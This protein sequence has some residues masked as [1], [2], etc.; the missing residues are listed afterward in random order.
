M[1]GN[2]KTSSGV[3]TSVSTKT[4]AK[5]DDTEGSLR[6]DP[7]RRHFITLTEPNVVIAFIFAENFLL[8]VILVS[9]VIIYLQKSHYAHWLRTRQLIP[10]SV[11]SW[12][13]VQK[14]EIK[15]I[16]RKV[17]KAQQHKMTH[18]LGEGNNVLIQSLKENAKNKNTQQSKNNW[19]S[20]E[21]L[22]F[23]KGLWQKYW[24]VRTGGRELNSGGV[25]RNS[26]HETREDF[27]PGNLRVMVTALDRYLTVKEYKHL[28][29]RDREFKRSKQVLE[30]KARLAATRQRQAAQQGEENEQWGKKEAEK[31]KSA[32]PYP[33]SLVASVPIFWSSRST[34]TPQYYGWRFL[35]W[36]RWKQ[37]RVHWIHREPDKNTSDFFL[38]RYQNWN[39]LKK[40]R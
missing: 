21:V 14:V 11:E 31:G 40:Y 2:H 19:L 26:S 8:L 30:G 38:K 28:I 34:G 4:V 18:S 13:W 29:I 35:L 25:L 15:L 10:N 7:L 37:H 9:Y 39:C 3:S 5:K 20:L 33:N 27:E 32:I 22:G 1:C 24:K 17:G 36:I 16:D 6:T 12:N 23:S